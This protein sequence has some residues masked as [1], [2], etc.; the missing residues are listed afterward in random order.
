MASL[1]PHVGRVSKEY[2]PHGY[3]IYNEV[4]VDIGTT[5]ATAGD[6]FVLGA[7]DS[8]IYI[9]AI[10]LLSE[11]SAPTGWTLQADYK[12]A[13]GST[14]GGGANNMFHAAGWVAVVNHAP[15]TSTPDQNQLIPQ[16]RGMSITL[17]KDGGNNL[18]NL[19]VMI[20]YRRKA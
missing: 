17:T 1:A 12:N 11:G 5:S 9:E 8:D 10:T 19:K 18:T 16:G 3:S 4:L 15:A 2:A 6:I 7:T 14:P 20:R 13:D